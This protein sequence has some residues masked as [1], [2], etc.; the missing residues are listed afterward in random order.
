MANT[1]SIFYSFSKANF[2]VNIC[3]RVIWRET[4]ESTALN[5]KL[6]QKNAV[7]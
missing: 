3:D 6:E 2:D 1:A 5:G 7:S 4:T